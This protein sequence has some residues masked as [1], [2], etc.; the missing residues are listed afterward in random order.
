MEFLKPSASTQGKGEFVRNLVGRTGEGMQA[1]THVHKDWWAGTLSFDQVMEKA[2]TAVDNRRDHMIKAK[3]L[4]AGIDGQDQFVLRAGGHEFRPTDHCIQ[5]LSTRI[6]VKSASILREMKNDKNADRQ[7]AETMVSIVHNS[8][9]RVDEDKEFRLRTY[10]DGTARA[11]L[12]DKYA[13]VDNRWYLEALHEFLPTARWSHDK[14]DEDTIFGNILIP[15]TIMD[16]GTDE[17]T[18]Y[19][20]M[21]SVGNCEIGKRRISQTPSIF[22]AICMNGCIWGQ[23]EGRKVSKVHRGTID[24]DALKVVLAE[25]IAHQL[26][27]LPTGIHKFLETRQLQFKSNAKGVIAAVANDLRLTKNEA[28]ATLEE[29]VKHE[30][31]HKSLFGVINAIT[32]AGQRYDASTWVRMDE[33]G[34]GLLDLSESRWNTLVRRADSLTDKDFERTFSLTA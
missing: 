1:G 27:M 14:S 5:Q 3:D 8:L 17:D 4:K 22:R 10:T 6:G 15:D 33:L 18:D 31:D 12:T 23:Q 9:R 29:Y 11:F 32:R 30:S 24:L 19:G 7:D 34:G 2:Q 21:V 25:N 28:T 26:Q 16:Y 20:G 13:P